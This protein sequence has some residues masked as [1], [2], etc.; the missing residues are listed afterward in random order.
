MSNFPARETKHDLS[1][2]VP[3]DLLRASLA[4]AFERVMVRPEFLTAMVA[5]VK[6]AVALTY[7]QAGAMVGLTAASISAAVKNRRLAASYALGVTSPRILL[8]DLEEALAAKRIGA[9]RN[10]PP[11]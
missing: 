1:F 6:P 10:P 4:D 8:Q 5:A 11:L 3:A 9:R 2:T 7:A